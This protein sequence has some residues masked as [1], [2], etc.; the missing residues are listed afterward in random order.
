V[1]VPVHPPACRPPTLLPLPPAAAGD[2]HT[3][4]VGSAAAGYT[5]PLGRASITK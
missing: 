4:E 3:I 1:P 2:E 5:N